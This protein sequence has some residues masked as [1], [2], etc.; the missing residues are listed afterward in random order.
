M[1]ET[2]FSFAATAWDKLSKALDG[3]VDPDRFAAFSGTV[4]LPFPAGDHRAVAVKVIDSRGNEVM[5]VHQ[6]PETGD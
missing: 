3:V 6:I 5:R 4:S 2:P 1:T